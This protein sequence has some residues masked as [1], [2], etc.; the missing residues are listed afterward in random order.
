MQRLFVGVAIVS[1]LVVLSGCASGDSSKQEPVAVEPPV[2]VVPVSQE[3]NAVACPEGDL[4]GAGLAG[5]YDHALD[6]AV[7]QIAVQIQSSVTSTSRMQVKSETSAAGEEN[8]TSSYDRESLVSVQLR[9]RQDVHVAE[10]IARE[11]VVG[12]VACMH[13]N[14]AAKPFRDDYQSARDALVSSVAILSMTTH[15]LEKSGNY[16]KMTAAYAKYRESVQ[17]LQSLGFN[18]NSTE[19]EEKYAKAVA[20]YIDYKS[21]YK[22]YIDGAYESDEGRILFEQISGSVK[23]Q[24]VPDSC[25]VGIV[26]ELEI[27]AP[28]CK[29]GGLGISCTEVVALNGKSCSGES[30]FTLGG[31]L[32]GVGRMSEAEAKEKL[33]S[34]VPRNDFVADWKKEI[35]R[36][37]L[38]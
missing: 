35:E 4:R 11:G 22:V 9:N 24:S 31:T 6:Y 36:W 10:T 32:K 30:Y 3:L 8:I 18:E 34:N 33:L 25:D 16:E 26:L 1:S 23:L 7:N 15:P 2:R 13:R 29:E 20:D 37:F 12:V 21:R 38:K 19:I 17:V 28:N 27:S 5:D 14:D